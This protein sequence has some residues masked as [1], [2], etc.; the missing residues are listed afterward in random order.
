MAR[1]SQDLTNSAVQ[2]QVKDVPGYREVLRL[3]PNHPQ[4]RQKLEELSGR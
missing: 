1:L 3:D 2:S 4:A